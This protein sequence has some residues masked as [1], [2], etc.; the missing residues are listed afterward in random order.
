MLASL[1]DW[2][3]S[4]TGKWDM[5]CNSCMW[6]VCLHM[7]FRWSNNG[8]SAGILGC[9]RV[10]LAEIQ[11]SESGT[12]PPGQVIGSDMH[13][14][15]RYHVQQLS[16]GLPSVPL[17]CLLRVQRSHLPRCRIPAQFWS[18][19]RSSFQAAAFNAS[20]GWTRLT[21]RSLARIPANGRC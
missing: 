21:Q 3:T 13:A 18:S 1:A 15:W 16:N 4:P 19:R 9:C 12:A 6:K 20:A 5:L 14:G 11:E 8:H 2:Q 7:S 10:V 17:P